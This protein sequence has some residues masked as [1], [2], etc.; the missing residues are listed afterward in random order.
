MGTLTQAVVAAAVTCSLAGCAGYAPGQ[1][2]AM[3]TYEIC[4]MQVEQSWNLREE[5]RRLLAA[6]LER[7]KEACGPHQ[8]AIQA[9][10]DEALYDR[11]Y[12]NQSP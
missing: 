3:S 8:R 5:S 4:A 6:E 10:R 1:V 2:S 7:R 11:M 9:Q 12:R